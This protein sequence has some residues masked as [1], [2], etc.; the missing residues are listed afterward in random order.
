[1]LT[2]QFSPSKYKN[3]NK[4]YKNIN[5]KYKNINKNIN[6]KYKNIN[7]N[8]NKFAIFKK[9][10]I[11]NIMPIRK[12]LTQPTSKLLKTFIYIDLHG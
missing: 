9:N 2:P 8:I 3:I 5:K 7:K 10:N 11:K 4:K 12:F 1:M 6:K